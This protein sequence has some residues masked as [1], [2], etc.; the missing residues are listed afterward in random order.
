MAAEQADSRSSIHL[1]F[2]VTERRSRSAVLAKPERDAKADQQ[3]GAEQEED[4]GLLQPGDRRNRKAHRKAKKADL[5]RKKTDAREERTER[6]QYQEHKAG[7]RGRK[8]CLNTRYQ[9]DVHRD[10]DSNPMQRLGP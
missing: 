7:C 2:G 3:R 1:A 5:Q 4:D 9:H 6:K 10:Q 8:Q